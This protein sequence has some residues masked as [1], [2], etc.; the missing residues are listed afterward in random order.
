MRG[1]LLGGALLIG[2]AACVTTDRHTAMA[3]EVYALLRSGEAE[4]AVALAHEASDYQ[5]RAGAEHAR[6]PMFRLLVAAYSGL[7]EERA[8]Q[9][10][11]AGARSALDSA[12]AQG[13]RSQAYA[14]AQGWSSN[15]DYDLLD[16]L[17]RSRPVLARLGDEQALR[18]VSQEIGEIIRAEP[19]L[20]YNAYSSFVLHVADLAWALH[21]LGR[22]EG[23]LQLADA[24]ERDYRY[25]REEALRK[26]EEALLGGEAYVSRPTP[27]NWP[28]MRQVALIRLAAGRD[29]AALDALGA[30]LANFT[31]MDADYLAETAAELAAALR[32]AGRAPLAAR[33]EAEAAELHRL[34]ETSPRPDSRGDSD[35][36]RRYS[37][38][39]GRLAAR[40][41]PDGFFRPPFLAWAEYWGES[42]A[43][44]EAFD[45]E[46]AAERAR[47]AREVLGAV[48]PYLPALGMAAVGIASGDSQVMAAASR[49]FDAL[50]APAGGANQGRYSGGSQ[51][52]YSGYSQVGG[53]GTTTDPGSCVPG[54]RCTS[55]STEAERT[56]ASY[57]F[58]GSRPASGAAYC[59]NKVMAS[60]ARICA[61]ELYEMG[62]H[63]CAD[64]A[65]QQEQA[66]EET[67]AQ[68]A[69][70]SRSVNASLNWEQDCSWSEAFS[71]GSVVPVGSKS[72]AR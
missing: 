27:A 29:E 41:P 18:A 24:V 59:T 67:A 57:S 8:A 9:G 69:G 68:H 2:L 23:A 11:A 4:R 30:Y 5:E 66:S 63:G 7:A 3:D 36:A 44:Q 20:Y 71:D 16:A 34:L 13:R 1:V 21:E 42:V 15:T 64:L 43:W 70:V 72:P 33:L 47:R 65:M 37:E 46:Q 22:R 28:G 60:V 17:F 35:Y 39:Y 25:N 38:W 48:M 26:Y 32:A 6:A 52:G 49:Q 54:P 12:L 56:F 45:R 55:A 51:G 50:A 61:R 53:A 19:E 10:D 58:A 40:L 31:Q 62:E 14:R